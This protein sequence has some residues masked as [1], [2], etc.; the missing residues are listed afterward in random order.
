MGLSQAGLDAGRPVFAERKQQ[1]LEHLSQAGLVE[2]P[3]LMQ[4]APQHG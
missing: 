3:A 2:R 4:L 1:K